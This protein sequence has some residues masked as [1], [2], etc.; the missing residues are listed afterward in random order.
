[1]L[2]SDYT[3]EYEFARMLSLPGVAVY[4]NRI[5]NDAQVS[6]ASLAE[7]R[8]RLASSVRLIIPEGELD[9]VVFG[10]TSG[11]MVIGAQAVRELV[12]GV[13]P[14]VSCTTPIEAVAAAFAALKVNRDCIAHALR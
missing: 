5:A 4:H 8:A 6:A 9:V 10:C 3:I 11:S 14:G 1:M 7:M 12:H 13:R 2:S